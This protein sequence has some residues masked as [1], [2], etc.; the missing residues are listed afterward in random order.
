MVAESAPFDP[1]REVRYDLEFANIPDVLRRRA[2]D[3]PDKVA[4]ID[5]GSEYTYGQ[6]WDLVRRAAGGFRDLGLEKGD[7]FAVMLENRLEWIVGVLG[8]LVNGGILVPISTRFVGAEVRLLLELSGARVMLTSCDGARDYHRLICD[9]LGTAPVERVVVVGASSSGEITSWDDLLANPLGAAELDALVD[10]ITGDDISDIMF[11]SGTT[12]T[13]KGVV[14][15]HGQSVRAHGQL[16][17]S[18]GYRGDDRV[19]VIPPFFHTWGYKSGWLGCMLLGSTSIPVRR[20]DAVSTM[21]L[22]ERFG[23]TALPG[24]PTVFHDILDSPER[25]DYDLTSLRL[26]FPAAT[27]VPASLVLRI[28]NELGIALVTTAYGLTETMATVTANN[29]TDTVERITET[30][31]RPIP[32]CE[33]RIVDVAT[34]AVVGPGETGEIEVRGFNVTSGYWDNPAAT[35]ELFDGQWARSGDIGTM[36][37]DGYVR[38]TDRKKDMFIMGGFNAYPAEIEHVLSEYPGLQRV[39]VIGVPDERSGEVGAAFVVPRPGAVIDE[40]AVIAWSRERMANF[41]V[42]RYVHVVD[43]LVYNASGK[44]LKGALRE[45]HRRIV[46]PSPGVLS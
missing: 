34:N 36:D 28:R 16:I 38:V 41:K 32:G 3:M 29:P 9:D 14:A 27:T 45:Q 24:P 1:T 5:E 35:Q 43:D 13:P 6:V 33:V 20:H 19:V 37:A 2:H 31:G 22:I 25:G 11:T 40:A 15:R 4:V 8:G 30:V 18:A 44:V 17:T 12:G 10:G 23:A 7:R 26:A 39:S 42:P 46:E 21:A